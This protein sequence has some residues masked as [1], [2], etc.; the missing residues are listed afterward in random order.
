MKHGPATYKPSALPLGHTSSL[1]LFIKDREK[2]KCLNTWEG[3]RHSDFSLSEVE[4]L[5]NYIIFVLKIWTSMETDSKNKKTTT[6]TTKHGLTYSHKVLNSKEG[7]RDKSRKQMDQ[8]KTAVAC[9]TVLDWLPVKLSPDWLFP[10]F[11]PLLVP[12]ATFLEMSRDVTC[13]KFM[14][15]PIT[16]KRQRFKMILTEQL[17]NTFVHCSSLLCKQRKKNSE[18]IT[19]ITNLASWLVPSCCCSN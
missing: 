12:I 1:S 4:I 18:K 11:G 17:S 5:C 14:C 6:T 10:L 8:E 7:R 2:I 19:P 13:V 3:N 9:Q 15:K 16:A